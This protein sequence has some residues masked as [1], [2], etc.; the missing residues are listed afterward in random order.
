MHKA[1]KG[2]LVARIQLLALKYIMPVVVA[3]QEQVP[4][5]AVVSTGEVMEAAPSVEDL[6]VQLIAVE[7]VEP[8]GA[9][10]LEVPE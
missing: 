7:E 5:E 8:A 6:L 10:P 2:E 3:V 4:E 1:E 9:E